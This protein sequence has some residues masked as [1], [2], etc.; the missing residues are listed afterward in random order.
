PGS[1]RRLPAANLTH[2]GDARDAKS[3][4]ALYGGSG[5]ASGLWDRARIDGVSRI[6]RCNFGRSFWPCPGRI[7]RA[8]PVRSETRAGSRRTLL[9]PARLALLARQ[10]ALLAA[11]WH[12]A[13][14]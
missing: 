6:T 5:E 7:S 12:R 2:P 14:E 8:S 1:T 9:A 4:G 10:G 3:A 11:G 13:E